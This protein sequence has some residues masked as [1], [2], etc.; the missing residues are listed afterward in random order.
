MLKNRETPGQNG[1][2]DR[3]GRGARF[4]LSAELKL[5]REVADFVVLVPESN[6][7]WEEG[8]KMGVDR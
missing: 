6:G 5:A 8:M 1:R 4:F 3:Y 2:L 7:A